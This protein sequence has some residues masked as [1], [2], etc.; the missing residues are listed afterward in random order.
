[1]F[2]PNKKKSPSPSAN[3]S[4]H[5]SL[6]PRMVASG[7]ECEKKKEP[8]LG[9][10]FAPPRETSVKIS[11]SRVPSDPETLPKSIAETSGLKVKAHRA[12][13]GVD[14]DNNITL[15]NDIRDNRNSARGDAASEAGTYT[16]DQV[17]F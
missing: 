13:L 4:G 8:D 2:A 15:S 10:V 14:A 3:H 1:M 5:A 17:Q 7:G 16:I 9:P 6:S 12:N 11:S